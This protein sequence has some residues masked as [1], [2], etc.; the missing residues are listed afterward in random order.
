ML[1]PLG[2]NLERPNF[3]VTTVALILINIAAFAV[4]SKME[5]TGR[6]LIEQPGREGKIKAVEVQEFYH[7]WGAT[8]AKLQEGQLIGVITHMFMHGGLG[9]LIGNML[10]LWVFGQ[11]LETALGGFAFIVLYLFWGVV[12]CIT[13]CA[14][15]FS[16]EVFLIG[17]SGAIAGVMGA[18]MTLFGFAAKIKMLFFLG[19]LPVRFNI[20]AGVFGFIWIMQQM[21]NASLDIEG[22]LSGVAWMAHIGGFMI[23]L[24]TMLIFRNQTDRVLLGDSSRMY[25][26]KR[27]EIESAQVSDEGDFEPMTIDEFVEQLPTRP[28]NSCGA[29]MSGYDLIGDRL[30]RCPNHDCAQLCYLTDADILAAEG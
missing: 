10:I 22:A 9:H 29:E 12:A 15:D 20:P 24:V 1:L 8:P 3:P 11:S 18:Y 23:G 2:D 30:L 13:H 5:M 21:Y 14:T 19:P 4:V 16:S 6:H 27:E 26:G 28:C 17:A 7:T 25:F